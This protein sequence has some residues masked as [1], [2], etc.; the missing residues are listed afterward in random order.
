MTALALPPSLPA[1]PPWLRPMELRIDVRHSAAEIA[2]VL[3]R[4][5]RRL[6]TRGDRL[7]VLDTLGSILPGLVPHFR[8]ADGEYYVYVEDTAR[9]C[10]AGYTVFNRL[11]ELDRR[12]DRHLRAPHSK[13][14]EFYQRRGIAS[15]VYRWALGQGW[16]LVSGARQSEGAHALWRSL[17]RRH[18]CGFVSLD[19]RVLTYLG[20]SV[21]DAVKQR[22]QTRMLMLGEGWDLARLERDCGCRRRPAV[23]APGASFETVAAD[24]LV[25]HQLEPHRVEHG[26]GGCQRQAEH[27]GEIPHG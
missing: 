25:F 19:D 20:P 23:P 15:A 3:D 10:L 27:P 14:A 1:W 21:D 8:E 17:A 12:A 22:L 5:Y 2:E 9:G 24:G 7:R 11:I 6:R 13:Y 26:K 16:C 18:P 4:L